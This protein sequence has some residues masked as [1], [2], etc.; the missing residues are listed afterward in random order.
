[1]RAFEM[2]MGM[3]LDYATGSAAELV[4]NARGDPAALREAARRLTAAADRLEPPATVGDVDGVAEPEPR[5]GVAYHLHAVAPVEFCIPIVWF[6]TAGRQHHHLQRPR[7]I[8]CR[9]SV[10]P[11]RFSECVRSFPDRRPFPFSM[12]HPSFRVR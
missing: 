6:Q 4:L 10:S 5:D 1:M 11:F 3:G 2:L 8:F 12:P 7:F 9:H